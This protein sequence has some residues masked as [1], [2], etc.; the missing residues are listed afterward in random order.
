MWS[1]EYC[2]KVNAHQHYIR[3]LNG[4]N[5]LQSTGR[6]ISFVTLTS[7]ENN[8]TTDR[9]LDVWRKSWRALRER[10]RRL[11]KKNCEYD[12]SFCIV[13]EFHKNKRLHW[14]LLCSYV[15]TTRWWKDNARSCGLGYQAKSV[16][17]DNGA[18]AA[19]YITKYLAKSLTQSDFPRKMRRVVYSQSF[20][21]KVTHPSD[22]I[23]EVLDPKESLIN[24]IYAGWNKD[25][26]TYLHFEQITE[27]L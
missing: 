2:G 22:Y 18:Q 15:A 26:D 12:L 21:A 11:Q 24:A 3:I 6:R 23:W 27:I 14:H 10:Y 9:C 20:P 16:E 13:T 1:C 25:L 17:V 8:R 7:H 19:N 4:V 5:E